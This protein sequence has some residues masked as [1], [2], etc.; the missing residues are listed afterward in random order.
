M[1]ILPVPDSGNRKM[2]KNH[3]KRIGIA[4]LATVCAASAS[5]LP[6]R[7]ELQHVSQ[8]QQYHQVLEQTWTGLKRRL[9]DA[10]GVPLVHRPK[11]E[12]PGDA[13]SEGVGYGMILALYEND[14]A[15]FNK[16]WG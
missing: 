11:S 6:V 14:Q 16:I 2:P 10:Y 1:G 9:I 4:V 8:P 3:L 15:Y 5:L 7:N 13:V 12:S